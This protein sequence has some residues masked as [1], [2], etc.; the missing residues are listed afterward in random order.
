MGYLGWGLLMEGEN[1]GTLDEL[2]GDAGDV[3]WG[4]AE[5]PAGNGMMRQALPALARMRGDD[6]QVDVFVG[7]QLDQMRVR[8][9]PIFLHSNPDTRPPE[10]RA[11][12]LTKV[13]FPDSRGF[14]R[15]LL[16]EHRIVLIAAQ[17]RHGNGLQI[18]HDDVTR[19]GL[20]QPMDP[21][22]S[23][24]RWVGE[25]R[26]DE[27]AKPAFSL[28]PTN[29]RRGVAHD[30]GWDMGGFG[31]PLGE[32][33]AEFPGQRTATGSGEDAQPG[34]VVLSLLQQDC[35]GRADVKFLEQFDVL[36]MQPLTFFV[37]SR[38]GIETERFAQL[39]REMRPRLVVDRVRE[40][41]GF[42]ETP[43]QR[44]GDFHGPRRSV[45]KV[46]AAENGLRCGCHSRDGIDA[47]RDR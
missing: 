17:V 47:G 38:P 31:D 23:R 9:T 42:T 32:T 4:V 40:D 13:A 34:T 27:H 29:E 20:L 39:S 15:H 41:Q 7:G 26:S 28:R 25:I 8:A 44:R 21:A 45:G 36:A 1:A 37:Q 18:G 14:L 6:D 33:L 43:G 30:H 16:H 22:E 10:E 35:I 2:A 24:F 3:E 19:A 5:H 46:C 12:A 11:D